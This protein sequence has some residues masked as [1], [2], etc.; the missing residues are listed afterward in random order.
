VT[1]GGTLSSK[2]DYNPTSYVE[3]VHASIA[4]DLAIVVVYYYVPKNETV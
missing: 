3:T 4:K 2:Y 1:G